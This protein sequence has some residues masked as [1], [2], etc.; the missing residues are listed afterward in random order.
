MA[1]ERTEERAR[2]A[3]AERE[4]SVD[5][6]VAF[7]DAVV[8]IALTLLVL[9]LADAF[10][11]NTSGRG[12]ASSA[13]L[14]VALYGHLG[15]LFAFLLGF[16]LIARLWWAHHRLF[17]P[18]V[19]WTRPIVVLD[20]LWTFTIVVVPLTTAIIPHYRPWPL[21]FALYCGTLLVSSAALTGIAWFAH[22]TDAAER[23]DRTR[24]RLIGNA[25]NLVSFGAALALG[26]AV[27]AVQFW[28]LL[29]LLGTDPVQRL[30]ERRYRRRDAAAV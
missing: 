4:R 8:A 14:L 26:L 25:V 2:E 20:L 12:Q 17:E 10:S 27:P 15:Q 13:A 22:R 19:R 24:E 30:L 7:T 3:G 21:S 16:A 6:L 29:L 23:S 18:I 1:D 28:A 5:R 11:A 9:P